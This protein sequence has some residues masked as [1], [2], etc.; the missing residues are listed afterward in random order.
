MQIISLL[1]TSGS[2]PSISTCEIVVPTSGEAL[3]KAIA[4]YAVSSAVSV[5]GSAFEG[6]TTT[7]DLANCRVGT[8]HLTANGTVY[9]LWEIVG[10]ES[11]GYFR[12]TVTPTP[13][14]RGT[15]TI[16]GVTEEVVHALYHPQEAVAEVVADVVAEVPAIESDNSDHASTSASDS[17]TSTS[18]DD[19]S[20]NQPDMT[21]EEMWELLDERQDRIAVLETELSIE[22]GRVATEVFRRAQLLIENNTLINRNR[23][24]AASL[25]ALENKRDDTLE[26]N[27]MLL[28]SRNWHREHTA[29]MTALV[30][31]ETSPLTPT[32][33]GHVQDTPA[34]P[35]GQFMQDIAKFDRSTLKS[36]EQRDE[37]IASKRPS[38][39]TITITGNT[40]ITWSEAFD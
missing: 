36:K 27:R 2:V 8:F 18:S 7:A 6:V 17:D 32:Y 25:T 16:S 37:L 35:V 39:P 11:V 5:V 12:T 22:K 38:T 29:R 34:A 21:A 14:Q 1:H 40:P 31:T 28:E 19:W 33:R 3:T 4:E 20:A 9:T 30:Q 10:V 13:T 26:V 23:E 15:V 24:L